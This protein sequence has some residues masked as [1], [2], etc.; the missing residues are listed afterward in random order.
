MVFFILYYYKIVLYWIVSYCI[1]LFFIVFV[2]YC[3][4]II[5]V[6]CIEL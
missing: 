2:L 5:I 4:V 1:G 6:F 3:I